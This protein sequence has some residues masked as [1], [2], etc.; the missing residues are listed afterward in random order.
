MSMSRLAPYRS[1]RLRWISVVVLPCVLVAGCGAVGSSDA[2]KPATQTSTTVPGTIATLAAAGV[3]TVAN[4]SATTPEIA[5]KGTTV[6][7]LTHWQASNLAVEA[8]GHGGLTG[9]GLDSVF[10]TPARSPDLA[11]VLGGWALT[12]GDPD[13]VAAD[14]LLGNQ[15]W[16]HPE[17]VVFPT[18][19]LTLFAAD[20]LQHTTGPTGSAAPSGNA[21]W[22]APATAKSG[23]VAQDASL[24]TAPCSTVANFVD[25]VLDRV[26]GIRKV[27]AAEVGQ[28]IS[29]ALGGGV[30]GSIV[31]G[32]VSWGLSWFNRA[33]DLAE[34]AVKASCAH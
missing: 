13:E 5:V 26:F 19:V 14:G 34:Q 29:G 27:T 1:V 32:L 11:D 16:T 28:Y 7:T 22:L 15:D 8:A 33:V 17:A 24:T 2:P 23:V 4:E 9:A 20:A 18:E 10:P 21:M 31:G 3:A 12:K 30:L 6:L 25:G